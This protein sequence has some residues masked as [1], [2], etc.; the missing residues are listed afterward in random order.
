MITTDFLSSLDRFHLIVK[1]RVTSKYSGG[2]RS[3]FL[4]RGTT[5]KDYRAYVPG[6][7]FRLID[8]RIYGR[9]DDLYVKKFEEEKDLT[10][11]IVIDSSSSMDYGSPRKFDYA[12]M[13]GAGI[14]YLAMKDNEKFRFSTFAD[15]LQMFKA[16]RGMN[17]LAAMVDHLNSIKPHG[18]SVFAE[19]MNRY[20]I[21]LK[22]RALLVV[23]SDFLFNFEE[24][25]QGLLS[26]AGGDMKVIQVLDAT[27]RKLELEGDFKLKDS[28]STDMLQTFVSTRL[29]T[30]Y[31][32]SL[33]EHASKIAEVCD[34][35]RAD[36]HLIT[37]D[38]PIFDAFYEMTKEK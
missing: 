29:K 37:T 22:T 12:S 15:T 23:I 11:H 36:Y 4:G 5:V 19:A 18:K 32:Q 10:V 9:T 31:K 34:G 26:V 35:L 21:L 8:W 14:A 3:P 27:E 2:R 1:K 7:D 30:E 38:T 17:H 6:D 24:I 33:E 13:L 16:E 20:K 28:E 25:E